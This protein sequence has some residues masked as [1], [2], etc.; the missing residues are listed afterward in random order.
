MSGNGY[1]AKFA[2]PKLTTASSSKPDVPIRTIATLCL[3]PPV[4]PASTLKAG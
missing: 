4:A 2:T 1:E 3:V